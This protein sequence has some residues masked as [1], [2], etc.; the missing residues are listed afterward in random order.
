M[1]VP[2]DVRLGAVAGWI[3]F[4][5]V[6]A[7]FIVIPTMLAGQPPTARTDPAAVIAYFRHPE[8]ALI[9]GVLGVFV[10]ILALVSFAM[11]LRSV[12]V[13][14]GDERSRAFANL[15]L[16][17]VLV[18]A[19]VYLVSTAIGAM[20]VQASSGDAATFASLFRL[21]DLM[22]DGGADVLEGAWIGA[23]AIAGIG[24]PF[25]R[26]LGWLGIAVMVSRWIKAFVPVAAVPDGI[27]P[28]SGVLFLAWFLAIVVAL[29]R[30]ARRPVLLRAPNVA[31]A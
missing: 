5:G 31:A 4:I 24:G 3:G 13:A 27:I 28:I 10:G 17:L 11:G 23:F 26:W 18:T 14:T 6:V 19:P 21:Y 16:A 9:D 22:Y 7:A 20:L 30:E 15:G 8:F 29:T 25:P 2:Y 1:G 12:L